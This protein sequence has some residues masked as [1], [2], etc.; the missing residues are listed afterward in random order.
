MKKPAKI[1]V[2]LLLSLVFLLG[3]A[4]PI[5]ASSD[6]FTQK[7]DGYVCGGT[8]THA[9]LNYFISA[10][11]DIEQVG[12]RVVQDPFCELLGGAYCEESEGNRVVALLT[13]KGGLHCSASATYGETPDYVSC[14]YSFLGQEVG[15]LRVN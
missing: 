7:V 4:L 6:S 9:P 12:G 11:L 10:D 15:Y 13:A 5:S 3:T 2:S 14:F 8:L 1:T